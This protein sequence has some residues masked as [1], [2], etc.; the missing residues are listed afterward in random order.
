MKR[1]ISTRI[2]SLLLTLALLL[3]ACPVVFAED[4]EPTQPVVTVEPEAPQVPEEPVIEEEFIGI[5]SDPIEKPAEVIKALPEGI[6]GLPESYVLSEDMLKEKAEMTDKGNIQKVTSLTADKDYVA[7]Q[8]VVTVKSEEDAQ[9]MAEAFGGKLIDQDYDMALIQL[10][11]VDVPTAVLAAA[12]MD[13]HL[14]AA[15]PNYITTIDPLENESVFVQ[16]EDAA[17]AVIDELQR[18][19]WEYWVEDVMSNPDP[20]LQHPYSSTYQYMHDVVDTYAAW[21]VTTGSRDVTVAVIDTGVNASHADFGGRVRTVQINSLGTTDQQGHGTHVAGIIGASMN[22]GLGGAGIAPNISILSIKASTGST[23]SFSDYNV[24]TAIRRATNEGAWIINMSL[25]G[26]WYSSSRQSAINYAVNNGTTVIVAMGNDGS[27]TM[28]YSAANDG[29]IAVGATDRTNTRAYYSNYGSWADVSA[30]G[31]DIL[32][33]YNGNNTGYVSKSGTSMATPVVAGVAALYMSAKGWVSPATM[34]KVLEKSCVKTTSS[35]MGKGIVNAANMF[36][37]KPNAPS[38]VVATPNT[39]YWGYIPSSVPYGSSLGFYDNTYDEDW[40]A[41][42]TINGKNPSIKD[43][44]IINGELA[45]GF[46]DLNPYAGQTVTVRAAKINGMGMMSKVATLKVKVETTTSL[47]GVKIIAPKTLVSGKSTTL[48]ATVM[49]ADKASQSVSWAIVERS[50]NVSNVSINA[51]TGLLKAGKG[52]NGWVT[53]RATSATNASVYGTARVYIQTVNPVKRIALNASKMTVFAGKSAQLGVITLV[54]AYGNSISPSN[55]GLKWTS[56]NT[57]VATVDQNGRVKAIAKGSATIT[58]KALDGSNKSAKCKITVAQQ[59]QSITIT[60][61]TSMAPGTS[62]TFK[63]TATPSNA[64][65]KAVTWSLVNAPAGSIITAKGKVTIP[66]YARVGTTFSVVA[67][68][69]DGGPAKGFLVSVAPKAQAIYVNYDRNTYEPRVTLNSAGYVASAQL[70]TLDIPDTD[71]VDNVIQFSSMTIGNT[72]PCQWTSS[73]PKVATVDA[74]GKV[75]ALKAG[76]AKI[77][78]AA[79]DGSKKK[80]TVT[81]KVIVPSSYIT[82]TTD[83]ISMTN[84]TPFLAFGSSAQNKVVFG[85]SYGTPTNKG[86]NWDFEVAEVNSNG[87]Y[88]KD[89]TAYFRSRNLITINSKGKLTVKSGVQ[90]A[91][92]GIGGEFMV[93]VYA[94]STDGTYNYGRLDYVLVRPAKYLYSSDGTNFIANNN[95]DYYVKIYCD[96]WNPMGNANNIALT[97]TSSNPSV[98][99][100]YAIEYSS[101]NYYKVYFATG[102]FDGSAKITIKAADGSGK[103]CS[104]KVNVR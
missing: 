97:A 86:V 94:Y 73:N 81:I 38:F 10:D 82:I 90:D 83:R 50:G 98:V 69:K 75:T 80:A 72:M 28:C 48:S 44:E 92:L 8:I 3:S 49:P 5:H 24:N 58:C 56:S 13:L 33:V 45:T 22:N 103:S 51:K 25:G 35:G 66:A 40:Y 42:Y 101:G 79:Q 21:G 32:S 61:Q 55:C 71:R 99:S 11:S 62:A 36:N 74:T 70:Y 4:A 14:P 93:S 96:Q 54:D 37:G 29:V 17:M 88:V 53:V 65:N 57:K 15:Y 59:V 102:R 68:P 47:S 20:Y 84:G 78:C 23:G 41:I 89:W 76:T 52:S 34:E 2:L 95:G 63:A 77:T 64:N 1:R 46:I 60:G 67:T 85:D 7:D 100:V 31:S 19:D 104:F 87:N 39:S 27:N 91:W 30:P 18:K 16:K 12:D 43:G 6:K 26:Y 9:I